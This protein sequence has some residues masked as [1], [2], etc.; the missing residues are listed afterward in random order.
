MTA[1][2]TLA[3]ELCAHASGE[4]ASAELANHL[5]ACSKCQAELSLTRG[6]LGRVAQ[7]APSELEL[8]ALAHQRETTLAAWKHQER[9]RLWRTRSAMAL[10]AL[11][12]ALLLALGVGQRSAKV[13]LPLSDDLA[14]DALADG[15][16]ELAEEEFD[17]A[18]FDPEL[19]PTVYSEEGDE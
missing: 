17:P 9:R 6:V 18:A 3:P 13:A 14:L 7:P 1:C 5:Q 8:R 2:E 11:A 15:P 10:T 19:S 4:A 16:I 12:A